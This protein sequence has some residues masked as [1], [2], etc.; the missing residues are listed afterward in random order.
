MGISSM[1][2]RKTGY[3]ILKKKKEREREMRC[4]LQE[5]GEPV[6]SSQS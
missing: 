2:P 5:R 6:L 3:F 1:M 4:C